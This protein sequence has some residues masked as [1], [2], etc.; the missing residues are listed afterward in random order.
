M[1]SPSDFPF[2]YISSEEIPNGVDWADGEDG[3][4]G[5]P[6]PE[7]AVLNSNP[8]GIS[9]LQEEPE[10]PDI[11]RGSQATIQHRFTMD[12]NLGLSYLAG[13]GRGNYMQ[14]SAGNITRILT[15]RLQKTKAN[16]CV[17]SVTAEGI[18]FDTPPDEFRLDITELN[19]ALEKHPRYAFLPAD[20]RQLVNQAVNAAM[21]VS[22][23]EAVQQLNAI[24]TR[25]TDPP[26][27]TLD[28]DGWQTVQDAAQELLLKRRVGEDTFYLPGFTLIWSQYFYIPQ[29]L[30]PGGY[31]EDPLH[32]GGLPFYFWSLDGTPTGDDIFSQMANINPQF[33]ST[34]ISWLRQCDFVEYQRT[35]FRITHK[36]IGAPY[37]HWDSQVYTQEDSPYPPPPPFPLAN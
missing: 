21:Q 4:P 5:T 29:A 19:P 3:R 37:A 17:L 20:V 24:S 34:G 13:L 32:E 6:T 15:S 7:G 9:P 25:T 16:Q 14:D 30:N 22:Q 2:D 18:S 33:Y 35:W 11:E 26:P 31:I 28:F 36:W 12:Y 23:Q 10:S 1:P 27:D 8:D